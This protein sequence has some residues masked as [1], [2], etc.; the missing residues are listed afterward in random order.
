MALQNYIALQNNKLVISFKFDPAI[1]TAIKKIDGRVWNTAMKHWEVPTENVSEVLSVLVPLGFIANLDVL[2]LEE[3]EKSKIAQIDAIR[4]NESSYIGKLPL[5]GFQKI[6]ASFVMNMPSCLLADVPGLGKSIQTIAGTEGDEQVLLWTMSS[7]KYTFEEE[8]KKWFPDAKVIVVDGD[9]EA[10]TSQW[11]AGM[12]GI[13]VGGVKQKFKYVIANYELL[14]YDFD[15]IKDHEWC[16]IV[17]DEATRISNPDAST[18]RNLK[19]LKSK[20]RVALTGTPISNKP[21][22]VF[23]IIDWLVP[24]Y[25]GTYAQFKTKYCDLSEEYGNGRAY[26]KIIGYRNM[27]QLREKVGRFMLRRTKEEVFKDFPPKTIENIVFS[28]PPTERNMY[29]AIKEKLIKEIKELSTLNT[30]TLNIIPVKMLRLK[31]CTGHTKLVGGYGRGEST[32]LQILKDKLT[33]IFAN[34]EKAIVFTQF[35][36]MLHIMNEELKEFNP[37]LIY[38]DV[39]NMERFVRVKEFNDDPKPRVIIMTE[40]GAYGLNMQSASYVFHYDAPWS[41]AKLMQREDRAHRIG[42]NKPVTV[43]NMIAKDTIDEYVLKILHKKQIVSV[44]IL[45]DAERLAET[46]LSE[47][48]INAILRL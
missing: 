24:R 19:K 17:A 41:I 20:K 39:E 32:K 22:D 12:N 42:Q 37:I 10:R 15:L 34:G 23:S 18:T 43:Y 38:G 33:E 47:E 48:D 2:K 35:A 30:N 29:T 36:E 26:T 28:L 45:A 11:V 8:I 1:V 4:T 21:D 7:L 3:V 27:D 44:D 5:F 25:L 31:Q 46:G 16:T 13:Y 6:G 40:A 14:I 9:K